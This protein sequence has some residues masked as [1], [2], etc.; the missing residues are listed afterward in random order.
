MTKKMFFSHLF[1][2][3]LFVSG[4]IWKFDEVLRI[5]ALQKY[6]HLLDYQLI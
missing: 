1:D 3:V 5:C 6:V 4:I 2:W